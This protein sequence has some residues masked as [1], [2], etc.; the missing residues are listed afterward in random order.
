MKIV[1]FLA[2]LVLAWT[3]LTTTAYADEEPPP[4]TVT[5]PEITSFNPTVYTYEYSISGMSG[6]RR[7]FVQIEGGAPTRIPAEGTYEIDF[8]WGRETGSVTVLSCLHDS[9]TCTPVSTSPRSELV[10]GL[11]IDFARPTPR[12]IRVGA[13]EATIQIGWVVNRRLPEQS[14]SWRLAVSPESA[15]IVGGV[16]DD[17]GTTGEVAVVVPT[18]LPSGTYFLYLSAEVDAEVYGHMVASAAREV[19]VDRAGPV[20]VLYLPEG[21]TFYPATDSY[22]DALEYQVISDEEADVTVRATDGTGAQVWTSESFVANP[23]RRR[24]RKWTGR[25]QDGLLP[26]GTY[27]LTATGT[28]E[29]GNVATAKAKVRIDHARLRD[30]T[31]V[32]RVGA[33]SSVVDRYTRCGSLRSPSS[34]GWRGSLGFLTDRR[35]GRKVSTA[36]TL[37]R[38][39]VPRIDGLVGPRRVRVSMVGGASTSRPGSRIGIYYLARDGQFRADDVFGPAV[40]RYDG[41]WLDEQRFV[42]Q[43]RGHEVVTWSM[44]TGGGYG[45]D[46]R[47][48]ILTLS[49]RVL[50]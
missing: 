10:Y 5:W 44:G 18:E 19:T 9:M 40:R 14:L 32:V 36:S 11:A 8:G 45:Y 43:H 22:R 6:L 37:H 38:V 17:P 1:A 26:E 7:Y 27:L 46:V 31:K 23:D 3:G 25:S 39:R 15:P 4:P 16:I 30:S 21:A 42:T 28:D 49:F 48:F 35:C 29:L 47:E 41:Q 13:G 24:V 34:H 2:A 20:L 33:A 12:R 50:S